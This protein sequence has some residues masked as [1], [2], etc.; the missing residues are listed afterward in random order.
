MQTK[1]GLQLLDLNQL[2]ILCV[3][4]K[5]HAS[6]T[7]PTFTHSFDT[8]WQLRQFKPKQDF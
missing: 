1:Q 8:L 3:N 6:F 7:T 5:R 4:L 2:H